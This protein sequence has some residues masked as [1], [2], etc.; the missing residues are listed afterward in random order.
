MC[1]KSYK[2]SSARAS[3]M[4][5]HNE[6]ILECPYCDVK[7]KKRCVKNRH[8]K[9]YHD[10]KFRAERFS[11]LTCGFCSK[12]F[13][14]KYRYSDHMRKCHNVLVGSTSSGPFNKKNDFFE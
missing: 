9:F 8:I 1:P 14:Q 10:E 7:F 12:A 5:V 3:H 2:T 13:L 6:S 11:E 4:Q